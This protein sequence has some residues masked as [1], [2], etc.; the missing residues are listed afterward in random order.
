MDVCMEK[1]HQPIL[2]LLRNFYLTESNKENYDYIKKFFELINKKKKMISD[3]CPDALAA[4]F[5]K[6]LR[7]LSITQHFTECQ[8]LHKKLIKI[9]KFI[10][11]ENRPSKLNSRIAT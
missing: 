4:I 9:I 2:L 8:D 1:L 10:W 7:L 3:K 5:L 6:C 11:T